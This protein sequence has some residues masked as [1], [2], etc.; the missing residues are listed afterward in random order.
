MAGTDGRQ[1]QFGRHSAP[2]SWI[3]VHDGLR[4]TP[5]VPG[6]VL[7]VVLSFAVRKVRGFPKNPYTASPGMVVVRVDILDSHHD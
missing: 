5:M 4:E 2:F 1:L 7:D 3:N 6:E